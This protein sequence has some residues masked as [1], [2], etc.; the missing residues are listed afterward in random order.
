MVETDDQTHVQRT[1]NGKVV[2]GCE[3]GV[4]LFVS[5]VSMWTGEG[6]QLARNNPIQISVFQLFIVQILL[7]VEFL[8]GIPTN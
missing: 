4:A 2:P 1:E 7:N 5:F 8:V 3:V 6:Q